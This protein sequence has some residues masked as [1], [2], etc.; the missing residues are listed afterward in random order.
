MEKAP[1]YL[2]NQDFSI[3]PLTRVGLVSLT[4]ANLEDQLRFYQQVLGFQVNWQDDNEA[5]LGAGGSDIVKLVRN[6]SAT[7][8]HQVT[9]LYHFAVLLPNRRELARVTCS[10]FGRPDALRKVE[11]V[12]P[13]SRAS[14]FIFSEKASSLPAIASAKAIVA[15]LPD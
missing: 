15:S 2:S 11:F 8:Y 13:S 12:R 1:M 14:A 6:S 7:R 9:G 5:G 3:H 10:G 4:V